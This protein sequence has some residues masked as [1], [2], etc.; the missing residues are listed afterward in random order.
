MVQAETATESPVA[1][2]RLWAIRRRL[3]PVSG[4]T[5][6]M[7]ERARPDSRGKASAR[8]NGAPSHV[9]SAGRETESEG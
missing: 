2:A 5:E 1:C 8:P 6:S 7:A 3:W 9:R 4:G